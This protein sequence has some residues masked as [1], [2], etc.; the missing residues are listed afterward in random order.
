M[1]FW[2]LLYQTF[3]IFNLLLIRSLMQFYSLL[4]PPDIFVVSHFRRISLVWLYFDFIPN[5]DQT[6]TRRTTY[7]FLLSLV[8][9]PPLCIWRIFCSF[10]HDAYLLVCCQYDY[11]GRKRLGY[12]LTL[13]F[14][15]RQT[16]PTLRCL[17]QY[18]EALARHSKPV[19][20]A[21]TTA[22]AA[23]ACDCLLRRKNW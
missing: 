8:D 2:T 12:L 17:L 1:K 19:A 18:I 5:S 7:I 9:E 10:L 13:Y 11:N 22:T 14:Q 15:N 6:Q 3:L 23:Y 4:S 16:P 21:H 20:V